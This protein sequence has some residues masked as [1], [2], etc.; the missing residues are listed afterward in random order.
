MSL[1]TLCI[2]VTMCLVVSCLTSL[3]EMYREMVGMGVPIAMQRMVMLLPSMT[4][5]M[6]CTVGG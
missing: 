2:T 1:V 3:P 4:K 5:L 6:G